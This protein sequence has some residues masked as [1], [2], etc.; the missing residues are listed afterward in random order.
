MQRQEQKKKH[1]KWSIKYILK[2]CIFWITIKFS[3]TVGGGGG[4]GGREKKNTI[5][6]KLQSK[7]TKRSDNL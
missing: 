3:K 4:G 2:I 5:A 7:Q 6:T 1:Q